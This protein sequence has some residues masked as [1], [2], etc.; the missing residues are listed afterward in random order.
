MDGL[1]VS[2]SLGG[3]RLRE[4]AESLQPGAFPKPRVE[5]D[6]ETDEG[7]IQSSQPSTAS[8][9]LFFRFRM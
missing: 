7:K 6:V 8:L 4:K 3:H 9:R 1:G 5:T 2:V